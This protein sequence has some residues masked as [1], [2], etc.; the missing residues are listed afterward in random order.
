MLTDK[1][2]KNADALRHKKLFL[3]DMDGTIYNENSIFEGTLDFLSQ[4]EKME[5]AIFS[6]P[7]IPPNP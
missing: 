5:D 2:K 1:F 4:I 7:T 3:L 6:S